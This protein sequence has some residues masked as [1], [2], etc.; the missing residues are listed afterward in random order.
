MC[1]KE[2]VM[3]TSYA[4]FDIS[5]HYVQIARKERALHFSKII[6]TTISLRFE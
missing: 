4:Q 1:E 5:Q 3:F 6:T 2:K